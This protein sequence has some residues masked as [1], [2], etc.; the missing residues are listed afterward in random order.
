MSIWLSWNR[1]IEKRARILAHDGKF[2]LVG[3]HPFFLMNGIPTHYHRSDGEAVAIESHVHLFS[4]HFYAGTEAGFV[5]N[6]FRECIID[7]K[8]LLTRPKWRE[9]L[10]WPVSFALVW[11]R[12]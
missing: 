4:E 5:L 2:V 9:Y 6:E 12:V 1:P 3:Y 11:S 8:W 7:E 10:G